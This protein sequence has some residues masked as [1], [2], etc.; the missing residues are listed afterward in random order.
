MSKKNDENYINREISWLEFNQRVLDEAE[1]TTNPLLERLKFLAIVSSNLEEFFMVRVASIYDQ[2]KADFTQ[3]DIAGL[4]PKD[5]L[6]RISNITHTMMEQQYKNF[7]KL[8]VELKKQNINL[9]KYEELTND[10]K[11]FAKTYFHRT[12]FPVLTP[13]VVDSSRPFPLIMNK[14]LNIALFLEEDNSE[15]PLFGTIQ[16][17][18]VLDRILQLPTKSGKKS[19]ILLEDIIKAQ[20]ITFLLDTKYLRWATIELLEML[21]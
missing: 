12:V 4:T 6:H 7:H 3:P 19:F 14:S 13:M 8:V 2:V 18:G 16:V 17:P 10:Q 5:Q 9:L 20:C 15:E 1:D 11:D 21:I